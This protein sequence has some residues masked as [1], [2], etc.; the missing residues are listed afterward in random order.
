MLRRFFLNE[1]KTATWNFHPDNMVGEGGFGSVFKGWV[2]DNSSTASNPG[3]GMLIAVKRINQEGFLGH[4]QWSVSFTSLYICIYSSFACGAHFQNLIHIDVQFL[5]E[6]I[7]M[8]LKE[9]I[10][11]IHETILKRVCR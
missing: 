2:D 5:K 3:K 1:L 6:Q 4:Q 7:E 10:V 8:V 11:L 9:D